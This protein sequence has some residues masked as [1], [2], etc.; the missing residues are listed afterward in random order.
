M[1][2]G[3]LLAALIV[4]IG[5]R[6]GYGLL[7]QGLQIVL[8]DVRITPF[9][10][11]RIVPPAIWQPDNDYQTI[12]Q[13]GLQN[14]T[15][16][17]SP[18]VTFPVTTYSWFGGRVGFRSPQPTDGRLDGAVVGD[19]F[20][21]CFTENAACWVTL[22]SQKTGKNFA[23]LGQPV[24]GSLSHAQIFKTFALPVKPQVVIWQ[25]FGNDFNDD[26][27]LAQL[28][29]TA[30]TP[31]DP[32]AQAA[33]LPNAPLAIWLR[34]H[35]VIYATIS[36]LL[37]RNTGVDQFIDPYHDTVQPGNIDL[38]Y[39]QPYVQKAFDLSNPRN[40]E[41][42][43]RSEAAILETKALV[44]GYGGKF[45][46]ILMP[47]KEEIFSNITAVQMG[48]SAVDGI[49]APRRQMIE[50]CKAH[51][52]LYLDL[53]DALR[54]QA[55]QGVQGYFARDMHLNA[56]GNEAVAAAVAAFLK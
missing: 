29:G 34:E 40:L 55:D 18:E 16:A 27:G 13:P 21:F 1:L 35:S 12:T 26:Y 48:Q 17:G 33:A 11:A 23:N 19:S 3:L 6:L 20:S 39:G 51:A 7:P 53:Y 15:A 54:A 10:E 38:W 46:M 37:R 41:G 52:I 8:R 22:L 14:V 50:F 2:F 32:D 30:Q 9:T 28:Q 31:P 25:F 36:A 42:Q 45:V 5:V 49:A 44:E 43:K 24:T 47:T 4:E 56:Q